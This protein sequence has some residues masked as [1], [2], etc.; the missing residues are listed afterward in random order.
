MSSTE[1]KK[2]ETKLAPGIKP[3]DVQY[4]DNRTVRKLESSDTKTTFVEKVDGETKIHFYPDKPTQRIHKDR[5]I[6]K[7]P[8]RYYDPCAESSKM[9]VRCMETHDDDYKE[10]CVEYFKAYRECKKEWMKQRR[11]DSQNGGIW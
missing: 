3:E 11:S 1:D 4:L 7:E 9:A 5:F 2:S 10:V 6:V 8:S